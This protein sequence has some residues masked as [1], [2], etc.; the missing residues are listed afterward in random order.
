MILLR[1]FPG[2]HHCQSI[3]INLSGKSAVIGSFWKSISVGYCQAYFRF[4]ISQKV[5]P[6]LYINALRHVCRRW[7]ISTRSRERKTKIFRSKI[8]KIVQ[9]LLGAVQFF[10][11]KRQFCQKIPR[12]SPIKGCFYS[13][14]MFRSVISFIALQSKGC[15]CNFGHIFLIALQSK[16]LFC[17]FGHIFSQTTVSS[18]PLGALKY[19]HRFAATHKFVWV[20]VSCLKRNFLF[21]Q[22]D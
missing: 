12:S 19:H 6:F 2:E 8:A 5:V 15:F 20:R 11:L 16:G 3:L 21:F 4:L 9:K 18:L 17:N 22:S 14:F 10:N 1:R 13:I 7:P